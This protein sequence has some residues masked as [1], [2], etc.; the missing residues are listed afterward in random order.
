MREKEPSTRLIFLRHG[1]TDFPLDRIYCD[2]KEDPALNHEGE[3]QAE[4]AGQIL[5]ELSIQQIYVSPTQRTKQTAEIATRGNNLNWQQDERLKERHFG[6]WEGMYF[7]EIESNYAAEYQA[8]KQ[9][10]AAFKPANGESAFDL[11]ARFDCAIRDII[12][13]HKGETILVVSH[14]GPIRCAVC[15]ALDMPMIMFRQLRIDYA[16]ISC[17]DYGTRNLNLICLNYHQRLLK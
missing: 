15:H 10:P 3:A 4:Q 2:D 9:D 16:S 8:W 14:V 17:I 6:D 13:K 7:H 12:E 11:D 5:S 1:K